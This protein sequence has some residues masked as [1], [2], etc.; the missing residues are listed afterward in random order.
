MLLY[1]NVYP[2]QDQ[3][4]SIV[5]SKRQS[6]QKLNR[7]QQPFGNGELLA[8]G[9]AVRTAG[10]LVNTFPMVRWIIHLLT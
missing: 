4:R 7:V 6:I 10:A 5:F 9:E 8:F 1:H 2:T 3:I